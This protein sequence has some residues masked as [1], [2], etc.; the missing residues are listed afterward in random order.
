MFRQSMGVSPYQ[1]RLQQRVEKAKALLKDN[2]LTITEIAL[3]YGF[4]GAS[5][6]LETHAIANKP[7]PNTVWVTILAAPNEM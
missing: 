4:S 2:E 7:P 6:C 5:H 1:Y 3:A